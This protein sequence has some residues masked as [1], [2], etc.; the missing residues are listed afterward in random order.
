MSSSILPDSSASSSTAL[1]TSLLTVC[2]LPAVC[3]ELAASSPISPATTAKPCPASPARAASMLALSARRFVFFAMLRISSVKLL[4]SSTA[5]DFSILLRMLSAI[6][7]VSSF[8]LLPACCALSYIPCT[9]SIIL[10]DLSFP[11]C[12][13][14]LIFS[15]ASKVSLT[16]SLIW[17]SDALVSSMDALISSIVADISEIL[18]CAF[19]RS[20]A[21][22]SEELLSSEELSDMLTIIFLI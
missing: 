9:F 4:I 6:F 14:L 2:I 17:L 21:I 18:I 16:D 15:T 3:V 22:L 5:L 20:L 13:W 8:A 10:R 7:S 19:E 11:P 1:I 12:A